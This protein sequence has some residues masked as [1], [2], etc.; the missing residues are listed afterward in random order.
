MNRCSTAATKH[1]LRFGAFL[2]ELFLTTEGHHRPITHKNKN[3]A[4][5]EE[6]LATANGDTATIAGTRFSGGR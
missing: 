2:I 6:F 4:Q 1:A 3:T 5:G